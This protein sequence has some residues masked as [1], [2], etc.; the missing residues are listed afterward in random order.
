MELRDYKNKNIIKKVWEGSIAQE[1][2]IEKGDLI[3][4]INSTPIEDIIEYTFLQSDEYIE[5]EI[6]KPNG[7]I[8]IFEIEKE[9]DEE[10]GIEFSNPI[11]DAVKTCSND[12][13]FCFI[14]QLPE[15]MRESLY[16]KDDDSRLSFLQGNFITMTNMKQADIERMIR[17]R[18]SPVNISVHTTNPDLRATMLNNRFAGDILSKIEALSDAGLIMNGQIV[19]VPG[20]NDKSELEKT[21]RD[22]VKFYPQMQSLAV[23]PVGVT[24]H[25]E[26]LPQLKIFDQNSSRDLLGLIHGLQEEFLVKYGTRFVFASDEFYVMADEEVLEEEAYEGYIQIENGV[27]LLKQFERGLLEAINEQKANPSAFSWKSR[28]ITIATGSSAYDFMK[29]MAEKVMENIDNLEIQVIKIVNNYFGET[30]TVA[31]LITGTDLYE[32]LKDISLGDYL[33]LPRVMFRSDDLVF[34]DDI[35]KEEL[36]EKLSTKVV[37]S[38]IKGSEFLEK[39]LN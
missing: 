10:L 33:L 5:L 28:K 24:K 3:N 38:D 30:I 19:C 26:N 14:T 31:G 34:L 1:L 36:E 27:G 29:Q 37:V 35:T 11:I 4:R 23:V 32:Q 16:I 8:F 12:C 15:G 22:L 7:E 20:Y 2:G 25:R 6:E 17:Y 13:I 9:Y 39:I 18:I 21:I